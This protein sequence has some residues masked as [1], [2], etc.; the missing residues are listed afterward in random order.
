MLGPVTSSLRVAACKFML[1]PSEGL[2]FP[3][4]FFLFLCLLL[5]TIWLFSLIVVMPPDVEGQVD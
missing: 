5:L 3:L 2:K 4:H 1:Q